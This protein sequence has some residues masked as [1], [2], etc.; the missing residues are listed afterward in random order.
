MQ[1]NPRAAKPRRKRVGTTIR[2]G[3]ASEPRNGGSGV[4]VGRTVVE[5]RLIW[6]S[7]ARRQRPKGEK[8]C[9]RRRWSRGAAAPVKSRKLA[10]PPSERHSRRQ[11][12]T[13]P[14]RSRANGPIS[15]AM[16]SRRRGSLFPVPSCVSTLTTIISEHL[17]FY[18]PPNYGSSATSV[19]HFVD[20]AQ[21][22]IRI[23][24]GHF[25]LS[26]EPGLL[27]HAP[28]TTSTGSG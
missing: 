28:A 13:Q 10:Q 6:V 26:S 25:L 4:G 14:G 11:P 18:T 15:S 2:G 24:A 12:L 23:L 19:I 9:R 5:I 8:G 1:N 22:R 27:C 21:R 16:L 7:D 3:G 20:S 17:C